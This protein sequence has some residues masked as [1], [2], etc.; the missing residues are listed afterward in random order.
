VVNTEETLKNISSLVLF[1]ET[2]QMLILVK[3]RVW[4]MRERVKT[5]SL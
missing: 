3:K 5:Q 4:G 2:T 1:L